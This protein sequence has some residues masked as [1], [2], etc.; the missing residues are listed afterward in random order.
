MYSIVNIYR[1]IAEN[2][3]HQSF[4]CE[5]CGYKTVYGIIFT[6]ESS[7]SLAFENG[8]NVI[9]SRFERLESLDV[10]PNKR[11]IFFEKTLEMKLASGT[12]T[13]LKHEGSPDDQ[14][15]SVYLLVK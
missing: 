4:N 13:R 12:I 9:L 8:F 7:L 5:L 6:G 14:T 15:I 10:S 3:G 2:N 1:G 11:A